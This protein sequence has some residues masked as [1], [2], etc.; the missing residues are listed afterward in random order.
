MIV[1]PYKSLRGNGMNS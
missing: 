1:A